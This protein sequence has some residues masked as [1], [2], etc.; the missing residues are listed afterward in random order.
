VKEGKRIE[1]KDCTYAILGLIPLGIPNLERAVDDAL[2]KG[3][4]NMMVDQVTY[5][6]GAYFILASQSCIRVEGTV[7]NVAAGTAR[8]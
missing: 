5:Q 8:Q 1:G 7:L 6:E 3:N 2:Q 4:G